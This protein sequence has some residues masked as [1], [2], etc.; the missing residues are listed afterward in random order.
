MANEI[1]LLNVLFWLCINWA[2]QKHK[3]S[4]YTPLPQ[5]KFKSASALMT[6]K[7]I[8][9]LR[10]ELSLQGGKVRGLLR[11]LISSIF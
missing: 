5:F 4:R 10:T 11:F 1:M 9:N 2:E 3:L 8:F 7:G 6:A